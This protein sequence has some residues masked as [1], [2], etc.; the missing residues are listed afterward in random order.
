MEAL[1]CFGIGS[2][3]VA[4][5]PEALLARKTAKQRSPKLCFGLFVFIK[6]FWG[7]DPLCAVDEAS[8]ASP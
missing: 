3:G 5:T 2:V 8:Q 4:A 6:D 7:L 1:A